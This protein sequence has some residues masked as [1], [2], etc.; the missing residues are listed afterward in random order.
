MIGRGWA[1]DGEGVGHGSS[2]PAG[3]PAE[4]EEGITA[5]IAPVPRARLF[6]TEG[7]ASVSGLRMNSRSTCTV[8]SVIGIATLDPAARLDRLDNHG[9]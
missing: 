5:P 3:R 6:G 9:K 4:Q 8:K 1:A 2:V 7:T